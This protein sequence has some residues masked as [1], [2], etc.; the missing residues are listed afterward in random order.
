MGRADSIFIAT[1]GT[2]GD[3]LPAV[4]LGRALV[5]RGC[6]VSLGCSASLR[7]W[8]EGTG[9][10]HVPL[11][12][13]LGP[14]TARRHA[15]AWDEHAP[16][17]QPEPGFG[18]EQ[19]VDRTVDALPA[20]RDHD[21]LLT[22]STFGTGRILSEL[23]NR[24]WM[25]FSATPHH[26]SRASRAGQWR[27]GMLDAEA[28]EV[29]RAARASHRMD[30]FLREAFDLPPCEPHFDDAE[31]I[32][33]GASSALHPVGPPPGHTLISTGSWRWRPAEAGLPFEL[34]TFLSTRPRSQTRVLVE[35]G[36]QPL[37]D[38][39]GVVGPLV[40]ALQT[41][42]WCAIV[43]SGWAELRATGPDLWNGIVRDHDALLPQ[44]DL[45][46][47][48][49]GAGTVERALAHG[50]PL[51]VV[52]FGNDQFYNTERVVTLGL[53]VGLHARRLGAPDL[54]ELLCRALAC[55][56]AATDMQALLAH[57][58]GVSAA[59]ERV[60]ELGPLSRPW[61]GPS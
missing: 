22:G 29:Q 28:P 42:G 26:Y 35:I 15:W 19:R 57:E 2:L 46:I 36:S 17:E 18:L 20:A 50:R 60:L 55:G 48:H 14:E 45:V 43:L 34:T 56:G 61:R 38:P 8:L 10:A 21:L 59:A 11:R 13:D 4:A 54:P 6:R 39:S 49:G 24:P 51:A 3:V 52:P 9:V 58:P 12:P 44:V 53:G 40:A 31:H 1:A 37:C 33:L 41:L 5:E 27:L 30:S 23:A 32:L 16:A 47:T 7:P 25:T